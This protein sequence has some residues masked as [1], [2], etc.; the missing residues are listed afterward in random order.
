MDA[1]RAMDRRT[2]LKEHFDWILDNIIRA[3][4]RVFKD[5]PSEDQFKWAVSIMRSTNFQIKIPERKDAYSLQP[6]IVPFL[7]KFRH[8]PVNHQKVTTLSFILT[9]QG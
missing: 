6:A 3:Y 5:E 9:S 2:E 8:A 1:E 7:D 4:P